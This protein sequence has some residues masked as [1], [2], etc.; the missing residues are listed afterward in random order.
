MALVLMLIVPIYTRVR[1][2]L[3]GARLLRAVTMFFVI[4]LPLF[5]VLAHYR[6]SHRLRVLHLGRHLGVMVVSQM[7]TFAADSFNVKSGQRL[8]V[9]IMLGANLGALAGAKLAQTGRGR[10][11]PMGLMVIAAGILGATLLLA[12]PERAAVPEGSRAGSVERAS[13]PC[14]NCWA[15]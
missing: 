15:G 8:F 3:D 9:A 12:T 2:H 4:A 10:T 7:W 5:A 14:R 13:G 1:R 11:S 6:R